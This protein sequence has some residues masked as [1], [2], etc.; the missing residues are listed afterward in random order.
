MANLLLGQFPSLKSVQTT[1]PK[2][3]PRCKLPDLKS[4]I[5]LSDQERA[6]IRTLRLK[7]NSS[8][9][10]TERCELFESLLRNSTS[11][12][13]LA[14]LVSSVQMFTPEEYIEFKQFC[15]D[16]KNRVFEFRDRIRMNPNCGKSP[17]DQ[18]KHRLMCKWFPF[19]FNDD[20]DLRDVSLEYTDPPIHTIDADLSQQLALFGSKEDLE[21]LIKQCVYETLDTSPEIFPKDIDCNYIKILNPSMERILT[22]GNYRQAGQ[23]EQYLVF[24]LYGKQWTYPI[25]RLLCQKIVERNQQIPCANRRQNIVTL[26]GTKSVHMGDPK[27]LPPNNCVTIPL[28]HVRHFIGKKHIFINQIGQHIQQELDIPKCKLFVLPWRKSISLVHVITSN[29]PLNKTMCNYILGRVKDI[30]QEQCPSPFDDEPW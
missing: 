2:S 8:L 10:P 29:V 16:P 15:L 13:N 21:D 28:E 18:F 12:Q 3:P 26:N 7:G 23:D 9:S 19:N 14:E 6:S 20:I 25:A 11:H 5:T 22:F 1:L 27:S 17:L 24:C 30:D 4:F